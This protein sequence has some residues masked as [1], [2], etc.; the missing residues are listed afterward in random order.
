MLQFSE[1]VW[2]LSYS[3]W[4][5]FNKFL[6]IDATYRSKIS[7]DQKRFFIALSLY[8]LSFFAKNP[9]NFKLIFEFFP[10]I[11]TSQISKIKDLNLRSTISFPSLKTDK[12]Q[13]FYLAFCSCHGF[14]FLQFFVLK[15]NNFYETLFCLISSLF[16]RFVKQDE[17]YGISMFNPIPAGVLENQDP[18]P[19]NP[20]FYVQI[21]QMIHN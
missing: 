10:S 11:F 1:F 5:V 2:P 21:W 4:D 14:S 19:L 13:S 7:S 12:R 6:L 8:P 18:P 9:F 20:M 15:L 3:E 17:N 16:I